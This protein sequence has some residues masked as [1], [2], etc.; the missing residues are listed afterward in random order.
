[1]NIFKTGGELFDRIK[2]EGQFCEQSAV[3]VFKQI[4]EAIE[5]LHSRNIVHRDLKVMISLNVNFVIL[6]L[7]CSLKTSFWKNL[8]I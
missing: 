1:M 5:Y 7:L 6:F 8:Q 3:L 2:Q 4:L